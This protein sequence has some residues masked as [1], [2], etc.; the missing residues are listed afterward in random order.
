MPSNSSRICPKCEA[1]DDVAP[2]QALWPASWIC[3]SCGLAPDCFGGFARLAPALDGTLSGFD[4][5]SFEL[6]MSV[7]KGHF[8]F[9]RRNMLIA[10]LLKRYTKTSSPS[11][12]L[13]IGCGTGFVLGLLQSVF[14]GAKIAGSELH[15]AGL[16]IARQRHGHAIELFQ[17]DARRLLLVN[18]LDIVCAFDVL[19]HIEEDEVVLEAVGCSLRRSGLLIATVPQHPWLWSV[20]DDIAQHVRRYRV[21]E[22]EGKLS[23]IGLEVLFSDS[24]TSLL[25]PAMAASRLTR[26]KSSEMRRAQL[27]VIESE[28]KLSPWLNFTFS[29]VLRVEHSLRQLGQR[30]PL[31]G[32]RVVVARKDGT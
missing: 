24:F 14:P 17:L 19:E 2:D 16:Q 23:R 31:G 30:Y 8:W 20:S 29:Q 28:F 3:S 32:S 7:E 5:N 13:E 26:A 9:E 25:L 11:R 22:L 15:S 27:E 21:G 4:P 18:A 1:E 10:W 12:I 6:L